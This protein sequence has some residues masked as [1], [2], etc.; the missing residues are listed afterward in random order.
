M[1]VDKENI[2]QY[3]PQRKPFIMIDEL[4]SCDEGKFETRFEVLA[5]NVLCKDGTLSESAMV[6]NVAQSC[7]AG[8]GYI[9]T[10]SGERGDGLGFIGAVSKLKNHQLPKAG[11]QLNTQIEV[12][13]QFESIHLIQGSVF[14]NEE[15]MLQCQMKIVST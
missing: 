14:V 15:L 9:K 2:T 10:Q 1:L 8:F 6:E 7:A 4:V 5:D 13:N 12:L 3:I 11:D